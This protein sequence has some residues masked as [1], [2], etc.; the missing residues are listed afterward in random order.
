FGRVPRGGRRFTQAFQ[1]LS[2][3]YGRVTARMVRSLTIVGVAYALL[4]VLAGWRFFA[5]P[6]GFIPAQDQGY[7]IGVV[8]LPPGSSLQRTDAV[9]RQ[10]IAISERNPA[11]KVSVGFAGLDGATFTSAPNAGVIF[12]GLKPHQ[13]RTAR[14]PQVISELIPALHAVKGGD[15][16]VIPPPAV[17][18]IGTAGGFKMMIEDRTGL[19]YPALAQAAFQMMMGANRQPAVAG[20]FTPFNVGTPRLAA[21]IDRERA[22]RMGVPVQNIFS[23][24]NAYLG[25]AYVNDFNFLGRT[26]RVTAQAD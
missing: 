4:I 25:S 2:N 19:G 23:T 18:G 14:A 9:M 21:D 5:T 15:V 20:A 13:E 1:A 10:A 11:V 26:F 12:F 22:E 3:R 16:L 6:S 7:L 24:L 8:Q 17:Q